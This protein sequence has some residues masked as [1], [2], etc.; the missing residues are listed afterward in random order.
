MKHLIEPYLEDHKTAWAETTLKSETSRLRSVADRLHLG[1]AKLYDIVKLEMKPYAIK[2]LFIRIGA[3]ERWAK[4]EPVYQTWIKKH[5]NRFKHAYEKK[6][7]G[8]TYEEAI[9]R[10]GTLASS[11][12]AG[13]HALGIITSGARLDESYHVHGGT[14][15]GKGGKAR[16]VY[17]KLDVTVPKTTLWRKL[18]AIGLKPHDLRKL[19]A[20]NLAE[21]GAA[22]QDLCQ[23]F[24]WS[25]P[26]TAMIYLQGRNEERL[27]ALMEASV[28]GPKRADI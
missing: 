8:V 22:I 17:G 21:K 24:G 9:G 16:R 7:V 1:P 2:T 28:K 3:M 20:Q 14:V 19:C 23:I 27:Q 4:L 18:R 6:A 10:I 13:T 12:S 15:T 5:A 25:D 26:K 11:H